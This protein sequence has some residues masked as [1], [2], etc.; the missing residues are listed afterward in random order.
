VALNT[1]NPNLL[2]EISAVTVTRTM[3]MDTVLDFPILKGH[4]HRTSEQ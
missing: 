1:I 2:I 4:S 3:V